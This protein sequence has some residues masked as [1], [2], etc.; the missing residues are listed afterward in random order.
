MTEARRGRLLQATDT[1]ALGE[2]SVEVAQI[3]G[4]LIEQILSGALPAPVAFDQPEDEWVVL[5]NG[6]AVLEIAGE[7]VALTTG[8]WVLL[9]A[10]LPH[11]LI[12]TRPG[13]TWLALHARSSRGGRP[14]AATDQPRTSG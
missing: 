14:G 5:L 7:P 1:P 9:P 8:D 12:E 4:V 6:D 11:R 3:S 10:R 2:Y 13:T